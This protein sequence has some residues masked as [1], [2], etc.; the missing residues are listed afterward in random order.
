MNENM[1]INIKL[2][3]INIAINI[4][5]NMIINKKLIIQI[6]ILEQKWHKIDHKTVHKIRTI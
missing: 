6:D 2:K 5:I 3:I 4:I 1:D